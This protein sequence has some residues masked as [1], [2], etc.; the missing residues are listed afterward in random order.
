MLERDGGTRPK[1]TPLF[2]SSRRHR[3]GE[4]AGDA[5]GGS[6]PTA[7]CSHGA[8]TRIAHLIDQVRIHRRSRPS[9]SPRLQPELV[10]VETHYPIPVL[11][12]GRVR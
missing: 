7:T 5:R 9:H 11:R 3:S 8:S 10:A 2:P 6:A 4:I 12:W 1:D